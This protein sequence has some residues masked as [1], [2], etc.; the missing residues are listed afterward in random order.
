ML[1][2]QGH[3][4]RQHNITEP[5]LTPACEMMKPGEK[6]ELHQQLHT[7][8]PEQFLLKGLR[9]RPRALIGISQYTHSNLGHVG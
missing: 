6:A 5:I 9:G 2:F 8:I 7:L 4:H 3:K 1:P